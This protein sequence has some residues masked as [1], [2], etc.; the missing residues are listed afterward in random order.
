M[1]RRLD[2]GRA[3]GALSPSE[4]QH[5]LKTLNFHPTPD[6]LDRLLYR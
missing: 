4:F 5:L 2:R 3:A 6:L 1:L